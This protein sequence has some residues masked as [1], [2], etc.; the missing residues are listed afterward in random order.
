MI[1]MD[2]TIVAMTIFLSKP[3]GIRKMKRPRLR[4]LE[5]VDNDF[6]ELKVRRGMGEI[7]SMC[8]KR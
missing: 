3:D 1:R 7:M 5:D 4:W 8:R 2:Q 6:P